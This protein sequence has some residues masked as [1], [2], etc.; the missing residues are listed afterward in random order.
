MWEIA[1]DKGRAIWQRYFAADVL[2]DLDPSNA[3]WSELAPD[4]IATHDLRA[5]HLSFLENILHIYIS[6]NITYKKVSKEL[7]QYFREACWEELI[8]AGSRVAL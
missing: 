2:I 3:R 6:N 4:L 5:I 1:A 8:V 7:R